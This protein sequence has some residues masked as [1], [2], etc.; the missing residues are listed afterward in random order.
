MIISIISSM[1]FLSGEESGVADFYYT[2]ETMVEQLFKWEKEN[3]DIFEVKQIGYSQEDRLPIYAV[4]LSNNVK[5]NEDKPAILIVGSLHAEEIIGTEI[6]MRRIE[7]HLAAPNH[8]NTRPY[9]NELEL[10]FIPNLNPEGWEVV[11]D[12]LDVYYRKNKRDNTGSGEFDY[13]PGMGHDKDGVDL[14]RNFD[15]NWVHGDTLFEIRPGTNEP[16]DYYRGP[17]PMSESEILALLALLEEQHFVYSIVW[18][19]SRSGN[20]SEK[21]YHSFNHDGVYRSVDYDLARSIGNNFASRI[22]KLGDSST[23]ESLD[24]AGRNGSAHDWFYKE[25]GT[26]QLLAET[27]PPRNI[28]PDDFDVLMEVVEECWKGEEWLFD[29]ARNGHLDRAPMLTGHV[30]DAV[31]GEPLQAEVIVHEKHANYFTP[32][33]SDELYGRYWRPLLAGTYTVTFRKEGYE[34]VT[35]E[36]VV[37]NNSSWS[38]RSVSLEPLAKTEFSG[39]VLLND[40][41]VNAEISIH[42]SKWEPTAIYTDTIEVFNGSFSYSTWEGLK[43]IVVIAEGAY[44]HIETI[45]LQPEN[46]QVQIILSEKEVIFSENWENSTDQWVVDGPWEIIT[47]PDRNGERVIIESYDSARNFYEPNAD[48]SIV[49]TRPIDLTD[50]TSPDQEIPMLSFWQNLYTVWD[51][52]FVF[53]DVSTDQEEWHNLYNMSGQYDYWHPVYISL[54]SVMGENVY[55]RF[56]L[57]ADTPTGSTRLVD[58]G[59]MIDNIKVFSGLTSSTNIEFDIM[60]KIQPVV[61]LNQNYPNPFNPQTTISFSLYNKDFQDASIAIYNIKGALVENIKL[62]NHNISKGNVVWNAENN[63]SGVYLYQLILDGNIYQTRKSVLMK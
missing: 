25:Y 24:S 34:T 3:P 19:S 57:F 20:F 31:T 16:Y 28:Q 23:Y 14:N 21:V 52:D 10:W 4:K 9:L 55:L 56:R 61:T 51:L 37:V 54:E 39:T 32:R 46:H 5:V 7:K 11:T 53:V 22:T 47:P 40:N 26:I 27:G 13:I 43:D 45:N 6:V 8:P 42:N 33:L 1:V 12:G 59:W 50:Y 15:F 63:S 44:P 41:P 38:T 36:N 29:R 48:V 60:D 17:F 62:N 58:P 49:T 18:H 35:L 30:T 2:N